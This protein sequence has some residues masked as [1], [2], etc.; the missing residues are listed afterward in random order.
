MT[1]T[2]TDVEAELLRCRRNRLVDDLKR[3]RV[4]L[5]AACYDSDELRGEGRVPDE[6]VREIHD[7]LKAIRRAKEGLGGPPVEV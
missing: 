5:E 6:V 2:T 4:D 1:P 3:L 7:A